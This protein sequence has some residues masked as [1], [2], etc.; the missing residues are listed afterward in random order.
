MLYYSEITAKI[1]SKIKVSLRELVHSQ[2]TQ[3]KRFQNQTKCKE[4]LYFSLIA[5]NT[6]SEPK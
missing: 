3:L 1:I 6:T 2:E 5:N 4:M